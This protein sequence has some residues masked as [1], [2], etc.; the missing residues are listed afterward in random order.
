MKFERTKVMGIENALYG[1]RNPMNS[2]SKTDSYKCHEASDL[3]GN[4]CVIGANDLKLAS[5]LVKAGSPHGKF[6][7]M[8][9]VQV[10]ITAPIYWWKEMDTYKIG[11][12]ANS[13]STMHK[14]LSQPITNECFENPVWQGTLE[15]L[16]SLRQMAINFK[17]ENN[18]AWKDYWKDLVNE[19]PM[20]WLQTRMWDANYA[21]LR[22]IAYWRKDHKLTE[23]HEF[24]AWVKSLP[25]ADELIFAEK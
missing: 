16:E 3:F 10:Q 24:V 25:Y 1:M 7:R 19:L 20:G 12:T 2:W 8:I 22:N 14:L 21:I 4:E 18:D 17:N 9:H 23:W 13:T 11:T 15:R 6:A 5:T